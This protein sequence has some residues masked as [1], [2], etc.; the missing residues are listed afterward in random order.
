MIP[1]PTPTTYTLEERKAIAAAFRAAK[2]ILCDGTPL[3]H[4]ETPNLYR[5]KI[6]EYICHAL[7]LSGRPAQYAAKEIIQK[8]IKPFSSYEAWLL[9]YYKREQ[10]TKPFLQNLRHQW[11]D[12][13]IKEFSICKGSKP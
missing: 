1:Q 10:L 12:S 5:D 8:R 7:V 9:D 13:L 6:D 4:G 11:L 3:P 2:A